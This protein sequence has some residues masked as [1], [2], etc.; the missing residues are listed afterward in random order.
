[1]FRQ[2]GLCR[3]DAFFIDND[4]VGRPGLP[5]ALVRCAEDTGALLA[6]H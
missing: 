6:E 4:A 5:P 3:I 1:V 2:L